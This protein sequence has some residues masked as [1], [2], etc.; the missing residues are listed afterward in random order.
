MSTLTIRESS[1]ASRPARPGVPW[2]T[3]ATFSAGLSCVG[4]FWLVSLTGA[5]GVTERGSTPFATWVMLSITLLPVYGVAVL[6]A[7]TLAKRW[8]GAKP[9]GAKD[10]LLTALLLVGVVTVVG[11]AALAASAA[12]D[13]SLQVHHINGMTGMSSCTG[14]CVP[15]EQHDIFVLHVRGLLLVG[16]WLLLSNV[17]LVAWLAATW[18]GRITLATSGTGWT[19]DT[20]ADERQTTGGGRAS[21]VR[22]V[23]VGLLLGAAVIHAAVIPEHLEEWSAAGRFFIGLT[24]AE[25]AVAVLLLV[26]SHRRAALFVAGAISVVPLVAWLWSRT[27]GLP[28][29]PEAGVAEAIFVPDV[30]ACVLEVGALLVVLALLKPGRFVGPRISAHA[31]GLAVLI[32]LAVTAIGVAA[33]GLNWFDTFG[34]SASSSMEMSE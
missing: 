29:G 14:G 20:G 2:A 13:Y 4:A 34:V 31:R 16:Q 26:R 15:R 12:Y 8:F 28:F 25:V 3:L 23:L 7:M 5:I 18:G 1:R 17:V 9:G 19:G 30:L 24:L 10:A 32:L 21:D 6:G 11:I 33:T 27:L 22:L